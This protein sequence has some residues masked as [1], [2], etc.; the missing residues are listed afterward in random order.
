MWVA[1]L[2]ALSVGAQWP[3][4]QSAGW[5]GMLV[6]YAQEDGLE[7]AFL[8][9]FNGKNPCKV[10]QFVA[11][12][13]KAEQKEQREAKIKK[14]ETGLPTAAEFVFTAEIFLPHPFLETRAEARAFPPLCPPPDAV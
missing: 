8:K 3:L 5:L 11:E 12:G 2:L 10:C 1:L 4:L 7:E 9:T 13:R 6:S 14:I